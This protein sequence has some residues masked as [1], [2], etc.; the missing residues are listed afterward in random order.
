[1]DFPPEELRAMAKAIDDDREPRVRI[2]GELSAE[3]VQ[4][5][6]DMLRIVAADL[7]EHAGLETSWPV[8]RML[9]VLEDAAEQP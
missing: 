8:H 9:S 7:D 3:A 6:H 5:I 1:M 2:A 4:R